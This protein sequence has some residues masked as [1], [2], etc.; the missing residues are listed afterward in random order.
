[1]ATSAERQ[2]RFK[3]SMRE[4]GLEQVTGWVPAE[5][6]ADLQILMQRL[7]D[8]RELGPGPLRNIVT[9]KIVRAR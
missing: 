8:N 1:M 5:Y 6:V 2:R 3:T 4:Q 7:R 9:G